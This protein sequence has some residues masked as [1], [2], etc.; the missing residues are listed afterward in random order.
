MKTNPLCISAALLLYSGLSWGIARA[1][2]SPIVGEVTT[3]I[4]RAVVS[5][6]SGE[7]HKI[8]RGH[9]VRAGDRLETQD[10][11]HVHVRFIDGGLVSVRPL[12]R[13]NIEN[14]SRGNEA[15]PGSVHFSLEHG[16]VR[17]V[18]GAWGEEDRNR[19]RLNTPVVAI[20]IKGTDFVV[21]AWD[22]KTQAHVVTGA[23][24]MTPLA[25][26][27][28]GDLSCAN[29]APVLLS[30]D[31]RG[32]MLEFEP[33]HG[34][35]TPKVIAALDQKTASENESAIPAIIR[36]EGKYLLADGVENRVSNVIASNVSS[37]H[38]SEVSS[39]IETSSVVSPPAAVDEAPVAVDRKMVWRR[40]PINLGWLSTDTFS[41]VKAEEG[42]ASATSNFFYTLYRDQTTNPTYLGGKGVASLNLAAGAAVYGRPGLFNQPVT[43]SNPRLDLDFQAKSFATRLDLAGAF[44]SSRFESSGV[45]G[46]DGRLAQQDS[47]QRLSGALS[48]DARQAGYLFEKAVG[49][50]TVSGLTLWQK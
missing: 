38:S 20:G 36:A 27:S 11:G 5:D 24:F 28:S 9:S 33:K 14:Y 6:A 29:P 32:K 12:S 19:F 18:T 44:G 16:V 3:V 41:V 8:Q 7:V 39:V 35:G 42:M 37:I 26:C 50:G 1:S 25:S 43:I 34:A 17:S 2:A 10:G 30:A 13:L 49:I 21:Q 4:G 15:S 31:M 47:A 46:T 23:I 48:H 40:L 45:I 22:D